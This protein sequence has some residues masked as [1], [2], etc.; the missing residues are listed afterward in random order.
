M[1]LWIPGNTSKSV[2]G[3]V[4]NSMLIQNVSQKD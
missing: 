2:Q 1:L 4:N 3:T